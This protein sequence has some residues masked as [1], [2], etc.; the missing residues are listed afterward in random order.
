M[1]CGRGLLSGED[2]QCLGGQRGD[3]GSEATRPLERG[4][5]NTCTLGCFSD[6]AEAVWVTCAPV[7]A[8]ESAA[9]I[10]T[11]GLLPHAI[12]PHE[13][14]SVYPCTRM[15]RRE[16]WA[17]QAT[18]RRRPGIHGGDSGAG[19]LGAAGKPPSPQP[20]A[21]STPT[22]LPYGRRFLGGVFSSVSVVCYF[23]L[24]KAAPPVTPPFPFPP[25]P[26]TCPF[27]LPTAGAW[28][29]LPLLW[30]GPDRA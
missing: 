15:C 11:L 14:R 19:S 1:P 20:E 29:L 26:A 13:E 25:P 8:G 9:G 27:S 24:G 5:T 22:A 23:Y 30:H 16:G 18:A 12:C 17:E 10:F 7:L 2:C 6:A 3:E 28:W 4:V 21:P